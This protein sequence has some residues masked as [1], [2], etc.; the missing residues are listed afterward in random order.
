MRRCP[1]PAGRKQRRLR[2]PPSCSPDGWERCA[3]AHSLL[4]RKNGR[5]LAHAARTVCAEAD[6]RPTVRRADAEGTECAPP[7][8]PRL[9]HLLKGTNE[10]A[11]RRKPPTTPREDSARRWGRPGRAGR[12]AATPRRHQG[13]LPGVPRCPRRGLRPG[14][15]APHA[16]T[17]AAARKSHARGRAALPVAGGG[18]RGLALLPAPAASCRSQDSERDSSPCRQRGEHRASGP[19]HATA[20]RT[21]TAAGLV[22]KI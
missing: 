7:P 17:R 19:S 22:L 9:T 5:S 6:A 21:A 18:G 2:P 12:G 4:S 1:S 20:A 8:T 13:R 14:A 15:G 11:C 16:F 3:G 10:G